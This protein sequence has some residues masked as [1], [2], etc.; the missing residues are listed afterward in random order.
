MVKFKTAVYAL[1]EGVPRKSVAQRVFDVV[2]IS[3]ILGNVLAVILDTVQPI[4]E[5]YEALLFGFELVSVS[6]FTLELLLRFWISN[7]SP[8]GTTISSRSGFW[9][10]PYVLI[11]IVAILPFYLSFLFSLDLRLLRLLRLFRVFRISPYFQSLSLLASVLKQEYRPMLAA[12]AVIAIMML[13]AAGGIYLLER[14]TQPETFGD[15]PSA[16][17]WVVV[18][19][20][21]VG[22]GDAIPQTVLGRSLGAVIM[23]LGVGMVALPAGMLASRFSQVMHRQQDI[24]RRFV[25]DSIAV[26][27]KVSEE[28]VEQVRQE[29]FISH[30]EAKSIIANCIEDSQRTIKF[31]PNC[32]SKLPK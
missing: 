29:L 8:D 9:S 19:L 3:L 15:L 2:L 27:G 23:I 12:L 20:S 21:T 11:D 22:Y 7:F 30:S 17:W 1:L 28:R 5:R 31:C 24:F 32:G 18:T 14:E 26:E 16:L 6:V 25:E 4:H 13:F 10:N